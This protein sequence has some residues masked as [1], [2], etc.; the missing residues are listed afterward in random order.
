MQR[1]RIANPPEVRV[2]HISAPERELRATKQDNTSTGKPFF[3]RPIMGALLL[4]LLAL[5]AAAFVY[6]AA[7]EGRIF[8]GVRV[9]GADLGGMS[10]QEAQTALL[11]ATAGYPGGTVEV[12]G[13]NKAWGFAP[14]DLGLQVDADKTLDAA[15]NYARSGDLSADLE[16]RLTALLSG[17][18][19]TPAIKHDAG[20]VDKVVAGIASEVDKPAVSSKLQKDAGGK[21]VITPSAGGAYLDR[22]ALRASL[23]KSLATLPLAPVNL[24]MR[25]QL[26]D[27][28]EAALQDTQAQAMRLTEQPLILQGGEQTWTIET[29]QLRGMLMLR[30]KPGGGWEAGLDESVIAH[31][32]KPVA[33]E[34]QV[35]PQD[36][37]VRIGKGTVT[38]KADVPGRQL[39]TPAAVAAIKSG[40]EGEG[41][42]RTV[43]LP[44]K[45]VPAAVKEEQ[46]QTLY[47]K[48][49]AL[50]TQGIRLHFGDDGYILKGASVT[51]FLDVT[52]PQGGPG[53]PRLVV[54]EDVLASRISG[55][56]YYINRPA[57]DARFRMLDGV[58]TR[59]N[60]GR[61]G[62]KVNIA[63]S[64]ENAKKAIEAFS[65]S[66]RLQVDLAVTVTQPAVKDA[67]LST[68]NT[69]DLLAYG[70]TSYANSSSSRAWNVELGTRNINGTLVPPGGI[71]ST[72]DN[73][74]DLTLAA[75]FKMGYAIVHTDKGLTTVPAEA[76]GICQVSTTLFH[77]VFRAGLPVVERNWHSYWIGIYGVAPTGLPGLDA[78]IAPP[79]KDFRF[80]NTT[81]NWI[82][83]KSTADGKN[84][85]FQLYGVNPN[86]TVKIGEPVISGRVR[87][88]PT[89]IYEK[90]SALPA[91]QTVLVEHAQD[92]FNASITRTVTD[93]SGNVLDKWTA[94]SYYQPAHNRTL[95]GTGSK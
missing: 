50:V 58:P 52:T 35:E 5:P 73:I 34:L 82:L 59:L 81:G 89:M 2:A 12:R 26:P 19:I 67:D 1:L 54:D 23:D 46:V 37:E 39:D 13:N 22:E 43:T 14:A 20:L 90:T 63:P 80:K 69:P 21:V 75:G 41:A 65:G 4:L 7:H 68:I 25:E 55:V 18:Q 24:A 61:E 86:W 78:T 6:S 51:G 9:L 92:G 31:Y 83:I 16:G 62:L 91:G 70:Q 11:R 32:L 29:E 76:G 79:E 42:A 28:T 49:D 60:A 87:T 93:S 3:V 36:A 84:V 48:A 56:A 85:T 17:T 66:D 71:F 77:S 53:L 33:E 15:F 57:A 44:L 10:R 95:I 38:L 72:V 45:V 94:K 47:D 88:D 30:A 74:G 8:K 64:L 27:V 40:S